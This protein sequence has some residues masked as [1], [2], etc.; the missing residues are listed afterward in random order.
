ML[1]NH[2]NKKRKVHSK[3]FIRTLYQ[4]R[5][6]K[7]MGFGRKGIMEEKKYIFDNPLLET[8]HDSYETVDTS[9]RYNQILEILKDK[10]MTAK[11]IAVEMKNRGYS[12]TDERNLTS[13]RLN[14]LMNKNIVECIG[15]TKCEYTGKMVGVYQ[16]IG[17]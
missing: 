10:K 12:N 13:P 16:I 14:E 3:L 5:I 17:G 4:I 11:E 9:Q 8:R 1:E 6:K 7:S 15:K 2:G